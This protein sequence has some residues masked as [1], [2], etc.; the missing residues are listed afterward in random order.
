MQVANNI[1]R[2]LQTASDAFVYNNDPF[3]IL[4]KKPKPYLLKAKGYSHPN[5]FVRFW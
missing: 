3:G 5:M 1:Y 4:D 2:I